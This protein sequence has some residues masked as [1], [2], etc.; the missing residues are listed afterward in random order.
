MI[1]RTGEG[2][3]NPNDFPVTY[4]LLFNKIL[5]QFKQT[6]EHFKE[7]CTDFKCQWPVA[8]LCVRN[9]RDA[10]VWKKTKHKK[11]NKTFK[12]L[13]SNVIKFCLRFTVKILLA[14]NKYSKFP[15]PQRLF[16]KVRRMSKEY[17]G[18][19]IF[20]CHLKNCFRVQYVFLM[21][22]SEKF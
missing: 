12:F 17:Y 13:F 15:T 20:L 9:A 1:P 14:E 2:E 4:I 8:G 18:T 21:P 3:T 5:I 19:D 22:V 6:Q 10:F 11:K 16:Q 7:H